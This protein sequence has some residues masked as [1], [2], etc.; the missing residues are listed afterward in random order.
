MTLKNDFKLTSD[1]DIDLSNGDLSLISGPE[2][3]TQNATFRLNIILGEMFDDTR[4]GV[5]WLTD[6]V[7]PLVSIQSKKQ[8]L[9]SVIQGT[10][11][12]V[13]VD[14]ITI[15]VLKTG[16]SNVKWA[17]TCDGGSFSSEIIK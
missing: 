13:S 17:G 10:V 11:G 3:T 14:S 7:S 5:P 2:L 16:Q 12:A 9:R 6:M 4:Q 15:E 8:I 1:W